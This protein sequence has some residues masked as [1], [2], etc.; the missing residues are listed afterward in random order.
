MSTRVKEYRVTINETYADGFR[1][2]NGA[3]RFSG[4]SP[5]V[6][7]KRALTWNARASRANII[8]AHGVFVTIAAQ[9]TPLW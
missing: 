4:S 3:G 9:A 5:E 2:T 7:M 8:K 6:A 1:W